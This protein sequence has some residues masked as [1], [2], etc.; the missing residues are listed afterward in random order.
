MTATE[1]AANN[2]ADNQLLPSRQEQKRDW[3][4]R[5][6]GEVLLLPLKISNPTVDSQYRRTFNMTGRHAF[7]ISQYA[8]ANLPIEKA[9]E[10]EA[11]AAH[12]ISDA[13]QWMDER[14]NDM[15][16]D[17]S[18]AGLVHMAKAHNQY[19]YDARIVSPI[20]YDHML[21]FQ[22]ADN[23]MGL[24]KSL[25]MQKVYDDRRNS[26][27]AY[28]IK[29]KLKDVAKRM[30]RMS[31]KMRDMMEEMANKA[32]VK[33][34]ATALKVPSKSFPAP[35]DNLIDAMPDVSETQAEMLEPAETP[36]AAKPGKKR[37]RKTT[38]TEEANAA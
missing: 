3:L 9:E 5:F 4:D 38:A 25:W 7:Y 23:A 33:S 17:F 24:L 36:K 2:A 32:S 11:A 14:I 29:Q 27:E 22:R 28:E 16:A 21:L 6:E 13:L 30:R 37:S 10:L 15:K 8:R 20:S 26:R 35:D 19:A 31:E 18:N 34:A 1:Y 12:I